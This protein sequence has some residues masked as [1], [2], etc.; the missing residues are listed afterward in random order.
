MM[1]IH[2]AA[3][4]YNPD[5]ELEA[6]DT[7]L[8]AL[9]LRRFAHAQHALVPDKEALQRFGGE[10]AVPVLGSLWTTFTAISRSA[11][12]SRPYPLAEPLEPPQGVQPLMLE[13]SWQG[14]ALTLLQAVH[15]PSYSMVTGIF[16]PVDQPPQTLDLSWSVTIEVHGGSVPYQVFTQGGYGH[17][18]FWTQ[19]WRVEP[20][21]L[22]GEALQWLAVAGENQ[23]PHFPETWVVRLPGPVLF[24]PVA[25]DSPE[26]AQ[27]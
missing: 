9:L 22:P 5:K 10:E 17:G 18:D 24:S 13:A 1:S 20:A 26:S 14:Y 19:Q 7:A 15:Y 3:A 27:S 2:P 23:W 6:I 8:T 25:A 12:V 21:L 11:S 16:R 4:P